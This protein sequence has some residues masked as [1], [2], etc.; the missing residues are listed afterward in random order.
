MA[1]C[2]GCGTPDGHG[3]G[4]DKNLSSPCCPDCDHRDIYKPNCGC[5]NC[6]SRLVSMVEQ[7]DHVIKY[8]R[9]VIIDRGPYFRK[10]VALPKIT[11]VIEAMRPVIEVDHDL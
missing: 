11:K 3:S 1:H 4:L 2:H 5:K 8:C 7:A 6:L 10:D 9:S